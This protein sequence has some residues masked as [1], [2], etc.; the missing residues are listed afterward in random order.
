MCMQECRGHKD[1]A[2]GIQTSQVGLVQVV[3][4]KDF[5]QYE[6]YRFQTRLTNVKFLNVIYALEN[7]INFG[8]TILECDIDAK[9]SHV[10]I[11]DTNLLTASK[12]RSFIYSFANL[13]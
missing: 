2:I 1:Q 5:L 10:F 8:R 3:F 9:V 12:W 4:L 7:M 11:D 13:L 6:N